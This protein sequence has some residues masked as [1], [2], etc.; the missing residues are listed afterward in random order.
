MFK[1]ALVLA[2]KDMM[3]FFRDKTALLLTLALP[4]VLATVFGSAMGGMMGGGGGVDTVRKVN[5]PVED[6]DKT[7]ASEAFLVLLEKSNG[8]AVERVEGAERLVKN[9]DYSAAL[10]IPEGYGAQLTGGE[11]PR[12]QLLRDPSAF[13]TM[14]MIAGNLMPVLFESTVQNV[15]PNLMATALDDLGFPE[16]GKSEAQA[17]IGR[18]WDEMSEL[19]MRLGFEGAF[20]EASADEPEPERDNLESDVAEANTGGGFNFL[21]DVPALM[22]LDT[23]D[24]V[25]QEEEEE[26]SEVKKS[27]GASHAIAAM[28]VMMLMFSLVG[29]G[30]SLLEEADGGTLLRLQL[31]PGG[32]GAI[33]TGKF[34]MLA[35]CGAM[36]LVM[37]FVYGYFAFDMPIFQ[38]AFGLTLA[39]LAL[40]F[41]STGLGLFFATAC[42]SRKQMEG[43]STLVILVMSAVGG[44]WFP[45]EITPEWFQTAGLFT[46]TAYAMDAFH[47]LLWFGKGILP[48]AD[49]N[50]IWFELLMLGIIGTVLNGLAYRFYDRR[51]VRQA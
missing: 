47:G 18:T 11:V 33:M 45:R 9:G 51:Y 15:G 23:V 27:G 46:L 25:G 49:T 19:V 29:A 4:I 42:T 39:S 50:G 37:L 7:E 13:I 30:G 36:Q 22:G 3:L 41:A 43:L 35:A 32:G 34:L 44:A 12:I 8:L 1:T 28:A 38:H 6:F 48:D 17:V 16:S 40:L 10:V 21:E 2:K 24:V 20:D 26:R 5:L 31:T 14:Q